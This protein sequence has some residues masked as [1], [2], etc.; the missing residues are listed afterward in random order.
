MRRPVEQYTPT[1][2]SDGEHGSTVTLGT[3]TDLWGTTRIQQDRISFVCNR[4]ASVAI[5][6]ILVI[7]TAQYRVIDDIRKPLATMNKSLTL[8]RVAKPVSP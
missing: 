8:E 2:T 4:S 6:D 5:N 3:K 1:K 7:E